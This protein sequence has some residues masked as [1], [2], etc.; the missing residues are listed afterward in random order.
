MKRG[1]IEYTLVGCKRKSIPGCCGI[2]WLVSERDSHE[3]G[4]IGF[5]KCPCCGG[6]DLVFLPD[7]EREN[8]LLAT[9][10]AFR[11]R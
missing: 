1:N 5:T 7:A 8:E 4:C 2:F 6:K 3:P 10:H 11:R 9:D